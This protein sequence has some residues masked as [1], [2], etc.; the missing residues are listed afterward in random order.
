MFLG[1]IHNYERLY[2]LKSNELTY[3]ADMFAL[4]LLLPS[5]EFRSIIDLYTTDGLCDIEKV[6]EHFQVPEMLVIN[7]GKLLGYFVNN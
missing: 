5:N 4:N 7:H 3:E 1:H 6:S 2:R